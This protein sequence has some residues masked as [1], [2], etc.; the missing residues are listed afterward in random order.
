MGEVAPQTKPSRT[1]AKSLEKVG[2]SLFWSTTLFSVTLVVAYVVMSLLGNVM[3]D[4]ARQNGRLAI[5]RARLAKKREANLQQAV[6]SLRSVDSLDSWALSNGFVPS[7]SLAPASS[8]Q[9]ALNPHAKK[10]LTIVATRR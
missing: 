7:Y 9:I 6:Q 4:Q 1:R 3:V 8:G 10:Q 5:E 2:I